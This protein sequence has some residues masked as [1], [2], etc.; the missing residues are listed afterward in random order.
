[1][2]L[3]EFNSK[4]NLPYFCKDTNITGYKFVKV[5]LFGWFAYTSN[6]EPAKTLFDFIE[7]NDPRK[8]Y[9]LIT[10]DNRK[11]LDFNILYSEMHEQKL[12]N[13]TVWKLNNETL[14]V[15]AQ[16]CLA[17]CKIR[18][19]GVQ[20]RLLDILRD[21]G[22]PHVMVSGAGFISES[23]VSKNK[24]L[25]IDDKLVGRLL[26]P[27]FAAPGVI[28]S[29]STHNPLKLDKVGMHYVRGETGWMGNFG[30]TIVKDVDAVCALGGMTWDYKLDYWTNQQMTIHSDVS[31]ETA[32]DIWTQAKR[33][34]F[35]NSPL[36]E[37]GKKSK[38]EIQPYLQKLEYTQ[39]KQLENVLAYPL[40]EA[41]KTQKQEEV[42]IGSMRFINKYNHYT[43]Q[44]KGV[45]QEYTN[46]GIKL[47]HME[48][49]NGVFFRVG[50]VIY[51]D[52]ELPFRWSEKLFDGKVKTF[53]GVLKELFYENNIGFPIVLV[54][55]Q[56]HLIDVINR[57]NQFSFRTVHL[58][59]NK[60]PAGSS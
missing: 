23:L 47:D 30:T 28:A 29:L 46:F 9:R 32:C 25:S 31:V 48:R 16:R 3:N 17:Y 1:M 60:K 14:L 8:A 40:E 27:S 53:M 11:Y 22:F 38:E 45:S 36:T 13:E 49:E 4:V 44:S 56:Q 50:K 57:F 39:I 19:D 51:E 10:L 12:V 54:H 33:T 26:L 2:T 18:V 37:L 55:Y 20:T 7:P 6:N 42:S 24:K 35:T 15:E 52:R 5:P 43:I 21:L 59:A 34:Q 58:I 41:W